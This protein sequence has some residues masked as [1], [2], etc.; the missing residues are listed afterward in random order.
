MIKIYFIRH[1]RQNSSLCNIDVPLAE[2]GIRQAILAGKRFAAFYPLDIIYASDFIRAKQTAEYIREQ[3]LFAGYHLPEIEIRSGLRE[4][5]FGDLTG[6]NDEEIETIYYDFKAER[7]TKIGIEDL[8]F[9][10]GEDGQM[11][12][13]RVFPVLQEMIASGKQK[14]AAVAHGG[15]IRIIVAALFGRGQ[16][17][18]LRFV[19]NMENTAITEIAYDEKKQRFYLERVNDYAHLENYPELLRRNWIRN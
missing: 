8:K 3:I 11:V 4:I 13:E 10:G 1:G 2:E 7:D 6:R 12:W 17:D 19:L 14:I 16:F 5:D 15:T 18:R 9:P